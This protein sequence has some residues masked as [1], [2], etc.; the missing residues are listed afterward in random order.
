MVVMALPIPRPAPVRMV[1]VLFLPT[2]DMDEVLG[3]LLLLMMKM[4][5][6]TKE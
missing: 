3:I 4:N 6:N 5:K 2:K 1:R